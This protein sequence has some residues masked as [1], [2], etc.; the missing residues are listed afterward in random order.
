MLSVIHMMTI[1]LSCEEEL[2]NLWRV[3]RA[4][5]MMPTLRSTLREVARL[6]KLLLL[7]VGEMKADK[8]ISIIRTS[9]GKTFN[10]NTQ[11]PHFR[12]QR[13]R[14]ILVATVG[15]RSDAHLHITS[16][17]VDIDDMYS[18]IEYI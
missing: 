10:I 7:L 9:I 15:N 18:Y 6:E 3:D 4:I 13:E 11:Q 17:A 1:F 16:R 8:R 5:V 2:E 14:S 12:R